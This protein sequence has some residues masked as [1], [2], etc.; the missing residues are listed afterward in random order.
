M[1]TGN[2]VPPGRSNI[3]FNRSA[4][5]LASHPLTRVPDALN[6]R[7][8]NSGV[9]APESEA[10]RLGALHRFAQRRSNI[11][12]QR[13]RITAAFSRLRSVRAADAGR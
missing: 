10:A 9:R 12:M 1:R 7:P 3:S 2:A 4:N 11:G 5:Q 6:A 8:V 13:T